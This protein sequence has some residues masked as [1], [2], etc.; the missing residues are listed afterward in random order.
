MKLHHALCFMHGKHAL[1]R[2]ALERSLRVLSPELPGYGYVLGCHAFALEETHAYREALHH[3]RAAIALCP[4]DAWAYHALLHVLTMQQRTREGLSFVRMRG[5]RF[6]GGNNF[7]AHIA[8][9]HA[10][11][12]LAEGEREEALSLYDSEIAPPLGRDY[13]DLANCAS[14]LYRLTRAGVDVGQRWQALADLAEQR[15]GDHQLSFADAH[16]VLAL[17]GAGRAQHAQAFVASMREASAARIDHDG[18]VARQ[19]GLPLCE[20]LVALYREQP[21]R[22]AQLLSPLAPCMLRLGGSHAQRALFELFI[23]EAALQAGRA[24]RGG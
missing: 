19:L 10:L 1:M 9:H 4:H 21:A 7:V 18:S 14:L 3:A 5:R 13:R 20:G 2:S 12:A 15:L 16:Y 6:A 11:F 22:A 23:T 8:W 24:A 17:L